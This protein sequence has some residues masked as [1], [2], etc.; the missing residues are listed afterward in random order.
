[1]AVIARCESRII[2]C[3]IR[4]VFNKD[5]TPGLLAD[6]AVWDAGYAA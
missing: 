3:G 1:M 4:N 6:V 2:R 5:E